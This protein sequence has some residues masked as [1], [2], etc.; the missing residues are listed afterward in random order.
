MIAI[1]LD[2]KDELGWVRLTTGDDDIILVTRQGKAL[3]IREKTIR[4]SGRQAAGVAGIKLG[5]GDNVA[6][7]EVVEPEGRLLI[8]TTHGF[9][10]Q[11]AL[12]EYPVKGRATGGVRSLNPKHIDKTGLV[13]AARVVQED[14]EITIISASGMVVRLEVGKI[15]PSGR[16]TSGSIA[17]RVSAGDYVASLARIPGDQKLEEAKRVE[18]TA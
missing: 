9:A 7:M 4:P 5:S 17:M 1:N 13:A 11:C 16:A 6:S 15:R 2:T 10:K 12:S 14:D 3:R 8:V 18:K